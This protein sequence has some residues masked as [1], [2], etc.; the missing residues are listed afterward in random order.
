MLKPSRKFTRI[1]YLGESKRSALD[2]R[3]KFNFD[4]KDDPSYQFNYG[5]CFTDRQT[6]ILT[7]EISIE[8]VPMHEIS[9]ILNKAR[10]LGD[11]D[12]YEK[13]KELRERK[14]LSKEYTPDITVEE[15]RAILDSLTPWK[16]G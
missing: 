8:D 6:R 15:A 9:L 10:S 13:A 5:K 3:G 11:I 12:G 2:G 7:E 4:N 1:A 14:Q 16:Q